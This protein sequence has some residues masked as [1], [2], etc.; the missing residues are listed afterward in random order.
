VQALRAQVAA[1]IPAFEN[2]L[3]MTTQVQAPTEDGS[4][5]QTVTEN[6]YS[7]DGGN[8]TISYASYMANPNQ[9]AYCYV[10]TMYTDPSNPDNDTW[11]CV[12]ADGQSASSLSPG[13]EITSAAVGVMA[14]LV[15]FINNQ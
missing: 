15:S 4:G 9:T 2:N 10:Y 5:M 14:G 11:Q 8:N 3:I 6:L 13:V 1:A 7:D 12:M